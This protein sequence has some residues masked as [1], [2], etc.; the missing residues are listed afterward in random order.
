MMYFFRNSKRRNICDICQQTFHSK[1]LLK[2]HQ[3][4]LEAFI[5]VFCKNCDKL[6]SLDESKYHHNFTQVCMA[7]HEYVSPENYKEHLCFHKESLQKMAHQNRV[8][9]KFCKQIFFS[10][11]NLANHEQQCYSSDTSIFGCRCCDLIFFNVTDL[12]NHIVDIR[13]QRAK[14]DIQCIFCEVKLES[15]TLFLDHMN[16]KHFSDIKM[17]K[18]PKI[19]KNNLKETNPKTGSQ[20]PCRFCHLTFKNKNWVVS[21]ERKEHGS[22][23]TKCEIC[24][25]YIKMESIKSHYISHRLQEKYKNTPDKICNVCGVRVRNLDNHMV[26]HEGKRKHKCQLCSKSFKFH[27]DL[28]RHMLVHS[29][30]AKHICQICGKRFKVGYNLKVHMRSHDAIKPF[31]CLVCQKTFTTKQWRDN[32]MKTHNRVLSC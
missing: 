12:N 17:Y 18:I 5:S 31:H 10:R 7:C 29:N 1:T 16:S 26:R 6:V 32:H 9:C 11:A 2:R 13:D 27:W 4:N 8:F 22:E 24:F 15:Q 20:I 25:Q 19:R 3:K 14:N 23:L 30:D 21:H 28:K